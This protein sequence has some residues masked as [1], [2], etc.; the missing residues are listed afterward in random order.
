MY[1]YET[2]KKFNLRRTCDNVNVRDGYTVEYRSRV[3]QES[4]NNT[5]Q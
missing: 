3:Q 1:R 5:D 4:R 2:I